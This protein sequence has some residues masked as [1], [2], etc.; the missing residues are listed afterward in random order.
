MRVEF[1]VDWGYRHIY[2]TEKYLPTF[3]FD[4]HV[5]VKKGKLVDVKRLEFQ[6]DRFGCHVLTPIAIPYEKS[7]WTSTVCNNYD[8]FTFLVE[9]DDS[10]EIEINTVSASGKFTI[11]ELL[12]KNVSKS[13]IARLMGCTWSTLNRYIKDSI[14]TY[15]Q[16]RNG[17]NF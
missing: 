8:G 16:N 1:S 17:C 13:E 12:N 2:F 15:P 10:T 5:E 14:D 9:G 6:E 11:K 4:G 7:E 3:C